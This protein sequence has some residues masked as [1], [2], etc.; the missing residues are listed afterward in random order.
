MSLID[1]STIRRLA[2]MSGCY[3]PALNWLRS[4]RRDH[5]NVSVS[6]FIV[7]FSADPE[8]DFSN[9]GY[10]ILLNLTCIP[11]AVRLSWL[12]NAIHSHVFR[13]AILTL[14]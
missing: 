13:R 11:W 12:E 9:L 1:Y 6:C 7:N 2:L 10:D 14:K 5:I 3:T 4:H 8:F